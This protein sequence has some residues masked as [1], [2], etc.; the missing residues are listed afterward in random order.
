MFSWGEP[1]RYRSLVQPLLHRD[2]YMLLADFA[3]YQHAQGLADELYV[4]PADWAERTLRNIAGM[5][6]FSTDRTI[7][8]YVQHVWAAPKPH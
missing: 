6:A 3:D 5:G 4:R 2:P 8:E 1:D 7:R